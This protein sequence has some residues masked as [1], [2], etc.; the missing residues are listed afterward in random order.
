MPQDSSEQSDSQDIKQWR[1]E[2]ACVLS[3]FT[4]ILKYRKLKDNPY[5]FEK[6]LQEHNLTGIIENEN[7]KA[8]QKPIKDHSIKD[9]KNP[10]WLLNVSALLE[11]RCKGAESLL[12]SLTMPF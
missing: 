8:L 9:E 7:L 4:E 3:T 6:L 2:N 11:A 5:K 12:L 10:K 1:K